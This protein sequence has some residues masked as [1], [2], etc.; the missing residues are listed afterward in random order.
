MLSR[1]HVWA[2]M[3]L[4]VIHSSTPSESV[5]VGMPNVC[6]RANGLQYNQHHR[7]E[8][9]TH[10]NVVFMG[11]LR[12]G[13]PLEYTFNPFTGSLLCRLRGGEPSHILCAAVGSVDF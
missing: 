3:K 13:I 4:A 9:P 1:D 2:I 6:D 10:I 11:V 7:E 8:T 12:S 5:A